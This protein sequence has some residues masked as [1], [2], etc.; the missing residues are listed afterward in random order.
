MYDFRCIIE[1]E[2]LFEQVL[3]S[4]REG[5]TGALLKDGYS[6]KYDV[7][8]PLEMFYQIIIDLRDRLSSLPDVNRI[9]GYGHLGEVLLLIIVHMCLY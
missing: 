6:Y 5:I 3:W 2:L 7:S 9:C 4:I 8:L 1:K